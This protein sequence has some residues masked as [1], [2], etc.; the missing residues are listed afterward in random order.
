MVNDICSWL[1]K[2]VIIVMPPR[3]SI[4]QGPKVRGWGWRGRASCRERGGGAELEG[5]RGWRERGG[6]AGGKE[7]ME[8]EGRRGERESWREGG[9]GGKEGGGSWRGRAGGKEGRSWRGRAGGKEGTELERESWR[10]GGGGGWRGRAGGKEGEGAVE[11]EGRVAV[12]G[13][14]EGRGM[15]GGGREGRRW[16]RLDERGSCKEGERLEEGRVARLPFLSLQISVKVKLVENE[17]EVE[18]SVRVST[19]VLN[20][21]FKA[22]EAGDLRLKENHALYE[23]SESLHIGKY[24]IVGMR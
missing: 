6:G 18:L 12:G 1:M 10:E 7:G 5:R 23:A 20:V 22:A 3:R 19:T 13:A 16:E 9:G 21:I 14:V 8:L 24:D 15:G 11:K 4:D 2:I 17:K